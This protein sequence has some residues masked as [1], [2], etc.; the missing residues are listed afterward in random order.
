MRLSISL[1]P[2]LK[3]IR[4]RSSFMVPMV[5]TITAPPLSYP[6]KQTSYDSGEDHFMVGMTLHPYSCK[7]NAMVWL[8]KALPTTTPKG[9]PIFIEKSGSQIHLYLANLGAYL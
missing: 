9:S 6:S 1:K 5:E 2:S 7:Q 4:E 8:L 3:Y